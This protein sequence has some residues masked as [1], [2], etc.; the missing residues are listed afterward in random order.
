M[1]AIGTRVRWRAASLAAGITAAVIAG[2]LIRVVVPTHATASKV[3]YTV[4]VHPPGPHAP[5]NEIAYGTV[6]GKSWQILMAKTSGNASNTGY[7]DCTYETGP[8]VDTAFLNLFDMP[9]W[10]PT[11]ATPADPVVYGL[12]M[13]QGGGQ[14]GYALGWSA[15]MASNV[16]YVTVTL[17]NGT[18][19]TL[20]PV[21]VYGGRYIAYA[22]PPGAVTRV[23]AYSPRG[24]IASAVAFTGHGAAF[25]PGTFL[26]PGQRGLPVATG[27]IGSGTVYGKSWSAT[28]Y[29]GP[30]G[31]CT[32]VS[33][34]LTVCI[35]AAAPLGL[36]PMQSVFPS[37]RVYTMPA[38]AVRAVVT[39]RGEKA[40]QVWVTKVGA[41][42]FIAF[43]STT[44]L[45]PSVMAYDAA[46]HAI[47]HTG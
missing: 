31:I 33:H 45:P 14:G 29:L 30:W 41:Q 5:A 7:Q 2:V 36:L 35:P 44:L 28:A 20:H 22:V 18:V 17:T 6:N 46:G 21:T 19:L 40:F 12:G 11:G 27:Q 38:S 16:S 34:G 3:D 26:R 39:G 4:T 13:M 37:V 43:V 32:S 42:K 23:T 24:E 1:T 25:V 47:A 9:C 10:P 15:V 8:A